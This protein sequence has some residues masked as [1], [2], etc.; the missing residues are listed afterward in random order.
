MHSLGSSPRE[1]MVSSID[2]GVQ[3]RNR[4]SAIHWYQLSSTRQWY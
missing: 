3:S 2:S 1:T 4:F